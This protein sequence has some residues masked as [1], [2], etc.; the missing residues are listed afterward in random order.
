[1]P[2]LASHVLAQAV[3]RLSID[4]Q[5]RYGVAPWV[6][7]TFVDDAHRGI[8]Y[9][10]ANWVDV[11]QTQ[12][13]GRQ[14]RQHAYPLAPKRV[15][16]Y[17][18]VPQAFP[19]LGAARALEPPTDWAAEEFG[20]MALDRRLVQRTQ[21]IARDFFARPCANIPQACGS[22][23]AAK[24]AYRFFDHPDTDMQTLLA[25]HYQSTAQRLQEHPL[26]LN[27]CDSTS[28]NYSTHPA[29]TG[30]GLIGPSVEGPIGLHMHET[31]V[32]TA[33]GT[34]LGLLDVQ[35]WARD[36][37]AFGKKHQRHSLPIEAKESYKWIQSW[38][39]TVK[40]QAAAPHTQMVMVADRESDIYDL[41]AKARGER[42]QLLIRAEQ[43]R[44]LSASESSLWPHLGAQP[45]AGH[46][47]ILT[48]RK[49][50]QPA[51]IAS[52][53]LRYAA[54]T[55][56]PP[57]GKEALGPVAVWAVWAKEESPPDGVEALDWMLITTVPTETLAHAHERLAWY[58][59]RWG[60]EIF[61]RTLKSGCKIEDRQLETA[62][63]LEACLAIDLVVAWRV[64]YL[65]H[66]NREIPDLPASVYFSDM[67][68]KALT[69]FATRN[70]IPPAVTP[71]LREVVTLVAR[72]G[73]HLG[74]KSDGQPGAEVLWRGLQR[75]DDITFAY[76]IFAPPTQPKPPKPPKP[77]P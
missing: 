50:G 45:A 70:P 34:P 69:A 29:T 53:T 41:L 22:I 32:F 18:L 44:K 60:I 42:A 27:V 73:G 65:V 40:A 71:T 54:V 67:Q 77:P 20:A 55:L 66:L 74:R 2:H 33:D 43:N 56:A 57:K 52:L 10:A 39:A 21:A 47:E 12:G 17:L 61:H 63:R 5:H 23:A 8:C 25:G 76:S 31:M 1:V 28:F 58:A 19:R 6:V 51:R 14:D 24:A 16:L 75:M 38:Q 4:W 36:R 3:Q 59:T 30:L 26:V 62:D 15:L 72:L 68:W 13:R 7:E 9:R 49:K 48:G 64:M 35:V 37:V 46:S 11:G